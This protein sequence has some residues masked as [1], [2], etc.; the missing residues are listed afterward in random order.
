MG[1]KCCGSGGCLSCCPIAGILI[2]ITKRDR[3]RQMILFARWTDGSTNSI[4][5]N[6][7]E[8]LTQKP[9]RLAA[10]QQ[11]R[12][13]ISAWRQRTFR[14]SERYYNPMRRASRHLSGAG[15]EEQAN[16]LKLEIAAMT[17]QTK[18]RME[19]KFRAEVGEK[20]LAAITKRTPCRFKPRFRI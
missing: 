5:S 10:P 4:A 7:D 16:S 20:L 14:L 18:E 1:R 2:V 13:V 6:L 15:Q 19:G 17:T 11:A 9:T 12:K 3:S 8:K